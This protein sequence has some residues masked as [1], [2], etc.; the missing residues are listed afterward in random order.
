MIPGARVCAI[1]GSR[2][3][4]TTEGTELTV[5]GDTVVLA[6]GS[7]PENQLYDDLRYQKVNLQVIGDAREPRTIMNAVS[8]GFFST[9]RA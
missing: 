2:V 3:S 5:D 4:Y 9:Y 8:E 6:L 7:K 1:S